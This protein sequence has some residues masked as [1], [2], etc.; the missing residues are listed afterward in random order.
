MEY[1]TVRNVEFK[2]RIWGQVNAL[3]KEAVN[4]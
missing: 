2:C 3:I 1:E 4:T